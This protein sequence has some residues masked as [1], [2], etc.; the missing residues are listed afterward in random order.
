MASSSRGRGWR[1]IRSSRSGR[2]S[3]A[4]GSS[5][6]AS[7]LRWVNLPDPSG[8]TPIAVQLTV[9]GSGSEGNATL[10][11]HPG[12]HVLVDAGLSYRELKNRLE[13]V[14]A[15][16]D[17]IGAIVVTHG[18]GDH[19]RGAALFSRRHGVTVYAT[20]ATRE[21]WG[22][23]D[24]TRWEP[25][26]PGQVV[27]VCGCRFHP[28]RVPHDNV[29]TVAFRIETP[30]G[31]IGFATDLGY[32]TPEL[33]ARFRGCLVLVLEAN[34][35]ADLLRISPYVRPVK[36]RI[37]SDQGHLSNEALAAYLAEHLDGSVRSV[38]LAH[39][40]RVNNLPE[41]A[42]MVCR[43]ALDRRGRSDVQVVVAYQDRPSQT[44]D[45]ARLTPL[46]GRFPVRAGGLYQDRLPF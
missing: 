20:P 45:L 44:V 35:A 41:I 1:S 13:S 16:A 18:H 42:V 36:E 28:F 19:V 24:V 9:L 31:A 4:G 6:A 26:L 2:S 22:G 15:T 12:G 3:R 32:V 27:D 21:A 14:G 10:V 34:H 39:L 38:V 43:E 23:E 5:G 46:A 25:L 30:E 7:W 33:V 8:R 40:S 37:A 17:E 11:A 29:E